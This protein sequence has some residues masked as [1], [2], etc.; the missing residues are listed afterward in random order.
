MDCIDQAF[1]SLEKFIIYICNCA[2]PDV[3]TE[4]KKNDDYEESQPLINRKR[5]YSDIENQLDNIKKKSKITDHNEPIATFEFPAYTDYQ[6]SNNSCQNCEEQI[7]ADSPQLNNEEL[8]NDVEKEED[9]IMTEDSTS[10]DRFFNEWH[11]VN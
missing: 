8:Y 10:I 6:F 4:M 9:D 7:M 2:E 11:I 3:Y 5:Q 1:N